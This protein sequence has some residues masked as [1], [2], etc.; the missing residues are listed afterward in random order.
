[1]R[2]DGSHFFG[3]ALPNGREYFY[4][5]QVIALA[6]E[7]TMGSFLSSPV[8]S[9]GVVYCASMDGTRDA[10]TRQGAVGLRS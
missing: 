6:H 5:Q 2:P 7:W 4:D 3:A 8:V 9:R 10:L 1:V